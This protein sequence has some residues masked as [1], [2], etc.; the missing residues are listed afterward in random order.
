MSAPTEQEEKL[1]SIY[2]EIEALFKKVDKTKDDK[3]LT[4]LLRDVTNKLKDAKA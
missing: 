3:K 2:G 1:Q 4:A